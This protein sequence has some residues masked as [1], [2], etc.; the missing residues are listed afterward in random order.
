VN[1]ENAVFQPNSDSRPSSSAA[2]SDTPTDT[3]IEHYSAV[4]LNDDS[5]SIN[6]YSPGDDSIFVTPENSSETLEDVEAITCADPIPGAI[7]PVCPT[8]A[9]PA[10]STVSFE[11]ISFPH[12]LFKEGLE[13]IT[14]SLVYTTK[15]V[16]IKGPCLEWFHTYELPILCDIL[17]EQ[18]NKQKANEVKTPIKS[19]RRLKKPL[20]TPRSEKRNKMREQWQANIEATVSKLDNAVSD[21]HDELRAAVM[22]VITENEFLKDQIA[23]FN[24]LVSELKSTMIDGQTQNSNKLK[25]IDRN[26]AS[27]SEANS[28]QIQAVAKELSS[29]HDKL[30]SAM[31]KS[32]NEMRLL[33]SQQQQLIAMSKD[34]Q[35]K[36]EEV[37]IEKTA[38]RHP[39]KPRTE[40]INLND[41]SDLNEWM[42]DPDNIYIGRSNKHHN[43]KASKWLNPFTINDWGAEICLQK[44][45]QYLKNSPELVSSLG[46]LKNKRLGCY[47]A[48]NACHG[49]ILMKLLNE[50]LQQQQQNAEEPT[51][52]TTEQSKPHENHRSITE[53]PRNNPRTSANQHH[54]SAAEV[55]KPDSER[56][57]ITLLI[58]SNRRNID[59][60]KLF[61]SAKVNVRECGNV[62]SAVNTSYNGLGRPTDIVVHVGTNDIKGADPAATAGAIMDMAVEAAEY[63]ECKVHISELTPRNDGLAKEAMETNKLL[64]SHANQ[65]PNINLIKH[66]NLSPR[67]LHD[68]VHLDR[69]GSSRNHLSGSQIFAANIYRGLFNQEPPQ[70]LLSESRSWGRNRGDRE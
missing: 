6:V 22:P 50:P 23:S 29:S 69:F 36:L 25:L 52:R 34:M 16:M 14:I 32:S 10:E 66:R 37:G 26:I 4:T 9:E 35:V 60:S 3:P 46:E 56:K 41:V 27:A 30:R 55:Q 53:K 64:E 40:V 17:N 67:H 31:D 47:C 12:T 48:P 54:A 20:A 68:E 63:Y 19:H 44:Y 45:E 57:E 11:P 24:L 5:V 13:L 2:I 7:S 28:Q 58:D 70:N 39:V 42:Q 38:V 1:A 15:K 18:N 59:F 43:I 51:P 8:D 49:G 65:C 62:T 61:P 33:G 21:L